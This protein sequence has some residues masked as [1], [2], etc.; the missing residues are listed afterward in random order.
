MLRVRSLL[1]GSLL[2]LWQLGC[3]GSPQAGPQAGSPSPNPQANIS[4]LP[5]NAIVGSPDL[6]L[7]ITGSQ[8]LS[9]ASG[10]HKVNRVVW[11]ANG[12]ETQ[13][14]A[15]FVSSSQLT[16][17]I[18]ATLLASPLTASVWVE[19]WDVQGDAPIAVS[20]SVPFTVTAVSAGSPSITSISPQSVPSGSSDSTLMITGSNFERGALS[21][22]SVA[23]WTSNPSNLHDH[24][25]M[26]NTTFISS[27]QL[28]AI[29][30]AALL[31]NPGAVQI[32]VLT[33]DPMG[34][35]DGYFGYP[36]SNSV[37]FIVTP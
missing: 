30:P 7:M 28:T 6:T 19:V 31:Q 16:V 29:I 25:T 14:S 17:T 23:F 15:T 5:A 10:G 26:L 27:S 1:L 8:T 32:V 34:V 13:L 21:H 22:I 12:S 18:P 24:G 35:S 2:V 20:S 33:G 4:I 37:T 9:F 36:K 11:S 3:G